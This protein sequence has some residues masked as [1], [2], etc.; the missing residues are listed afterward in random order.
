[1]RHFIRGSARARTG[2]KQSRDPFGTARIRRRAAAVGLAA[3]LILPLAACSNDVPAP[4]MSEPTASATT[5]PAPESSEPEPEKTESVT[6]TETAEPTEEAIS[7]GSV[8]EQIET[9]QITVED[10]REDAV[11]LPGEAKSSTMKALGKTEGALGKS[12][13]A[14][15]AAENHKSNAGRQVA[16]A[17]KKIEHAQKSID[18]ADRKLKALN[19]NNAASVREDLQSVSADLDTLW[20]SLE[21]LRVEN[22][23]HDCERRHRTTNG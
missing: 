22:C 5:E 11:G 6:P 8:L 2:L 17:V 3:V 18:R 21:D 10:I 7:N 20:D 13:G 23:P 14:A 4:E 16:D 19:N 12:T 15:K 9:L 1:M